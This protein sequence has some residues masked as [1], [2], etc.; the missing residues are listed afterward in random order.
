MSAALKIASLASGL[1]VFS[2]SALHTMRNSQQD[3]SKS[4]LAL[5]HTFES[6][7]QAGSVIKPKL[8]VRRAWPSLVESSLT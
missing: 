7:A 4:A 8:Y 3:F 5:E 2:F 6:Q 1:T